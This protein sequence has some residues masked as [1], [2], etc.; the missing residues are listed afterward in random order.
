MKLIAMLTLALAANPLTAGDFDSRLLRLIGPETRM[1]AGMDG[2]RY[3]RSEMN[4]VGPWSANS[5]AAQIFTVAGKASEGRH[6]LVNI[7]GTAA[8]EAADGAQSAR[9]DANTVA[10][11]DAASVEQAARDWK[12][13]KKLTGLAVK[14]QRLAQSFDAWFIMMRPLE[15]A[16][17]EDGAPALKYRTELLQSVEEVSGGV[18]VGAYNEVTLEAVTRTAEDAASLQALARW[19]PGL[20]QIDSPQSTQSRVIDL[21]ERL[22]VSVSDRTVTLS[23]VLPSAK[24]EDLRK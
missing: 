19:L 11:G 3:R 13:E 7:G 1:V 23:F 8:P 2:E 16:D 14:A 21:A 9:L 18:R 6:L 4:A 20:L 24:M 17:R 22:T 12:V 5:D 15:N 10:F